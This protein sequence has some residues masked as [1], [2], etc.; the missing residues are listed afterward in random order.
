MFMIFI[1]Q[2]EGAVL[3]KMAEPGFAQW[4]IYAFVAFVLWDKI[5]SRMERTK[6]QKREITGTVESRPER[7]PAMQNEVQEELDD[8]ETKIE[9]LRTHLDQKFREIAEAGERRAESIRSHI[10]REVNA[11]R[12]DL[13]QRMNLV[14]EKIN[15]AQ[16]GVATHTAQIDD[17]KVTQHTHGQ[18]ITVLQQ[19]MP[20]RTS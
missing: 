5:T 12:E 18:N 8:I 1:A 15:A 6:A 2:T 20:R 11:I 3:T 16:L 9:S 19:R 7:I 13:T 17:L 14:H 4:L 10:D